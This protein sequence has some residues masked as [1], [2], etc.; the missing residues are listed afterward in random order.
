MAPDSYLAVSATFLQNDLGRRVGALSNQP[1]GF[2][3]WLNQYQPTKV[4]GNSIFVY[5]IQ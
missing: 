1:G 4:I 3:S 5:H 2:Y